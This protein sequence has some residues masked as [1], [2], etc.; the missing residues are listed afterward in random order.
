MYHYTVGKYLATRL[1]QLGVKHVFSV[2]GDYTSELLGII[3]TQS[4]LQRIG[5]CNELNAGYAA[6]GYARFAGLGVVAVTSGV[7]AFSVLNAVAGSFAEHIPVVLIVGT[8]SNQSR[9]LEVNAGRRFHHQVS[10]DDM[11]QEIFRHVTSAQARIDNPLRAPEQIDAALRTCLSERRPVLIELTEDCYQLPCA[12]PTVPIAA[13]PS[14][15]PYAE[16]RAMAPSNKHAAQVANAIDGAAQAVFDKLRT[17]RRPLFWMGHELGTAPLRALAYQLLERTGL[18]FVTSLLGKSVLAESTPGFL[19]V[20]EGVFTSAETL[21]EVVSSDCVIAL[22]VWN[23]DINTLGNDSPE[24][25]NPA[26]VFASR[27]VVRIGLDLY[28]FVTLHNLLERVL[29]LQAEHP[30]QARKPPRRPARERIAQAS[31]DPISYDGFF[32][33]LNEFLLPEH[34]V[35]AD[36]GISANGASAFLD[37][38]EENGYAIQGLWASIGWSVPAGL[39]ASFVDGKRTIVIV[40]DGAF[41]LT[42][43]EIATMVKEARNTV[44]FVMN[45]GVYAVE[46]MFL[47][48]RP[49]QTGRQAPF[50]AANV[51]QRWDY[52]SLMAGFANGDGNRGKA[53]SVHTAAQLREALDGIAAT[54]D[55]CWLVDIHLAERDFPAAWSAIVQPRT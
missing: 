9:L 8:L 48:P 53:V 47:D 28:P 33:Q 39:G 18:P 42:C 23:T 44:V 5:N 55:C 7:G 54:P 25:A 1:Q 34:R 32:A 15:T 27:D 51:L 41:K 26:P 10:V 36:I 2:P 17:A 45:N 14:Y 11:N 52:V 4:E 12:A 22:G 21:E 24:A 3:D 31:A 29:Q 16:L 19:G 30:Y 38:A 13:V 46:Q 49:F 6:D 50:E 37:I 43:Q 35:V 20:Y 40:G